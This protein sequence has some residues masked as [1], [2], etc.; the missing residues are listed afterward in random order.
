MMSHINSYP[1]VRLNDKSP[2]EVAEFLLG[3]PLLAKM[4]LKKISPRDI[5][6]RPTLLKMHKIQA[7][8]QALLK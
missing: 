7:Q 5:Q 1:R 8:Q 3:K 4:N 2:F 6:L